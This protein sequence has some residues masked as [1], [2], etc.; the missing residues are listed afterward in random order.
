MTGPLRGVNLGGWLVLE[1]WMTPSLFAGTDAIDEFTFMQSPGAA[2]RLRRHHQ[3]FI[4]QRD[5]AWIADRGLDLV[6]LPVG[7]WVL[8]GDPPYMGAADLLDEAMEWATRHGLAVLL[9]LHAA[10]GSQNGRDHSGRVGARRWY[11]ERGHRE[12]THGALA[13]LAERYARHPA[14]WGIELVNEPTDWR[15]WRLRHFHREAYRRLAAQLAPGTRVVF[16]DGYVPWL[17]RGSLRGTADLP[18]VIDSHFYQAFY[19]WDVVRSVD[20][21]I[22]KARRRARLIEW[23]TRWQPVLVGEWSAGLPARA[24][25]GRGADE[26]LALTTAYV[27]AQLEGYAPALGWCF[28]SYKTEE[29]GDWNFRHLVDSGILRL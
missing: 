7:H 17:L 28:W 11:R 4:T 13:A 8:G 25:R 20:R 14:L 12:H 18:T 1:P 29:A 26:R 19:P 27:D 10:S 2:D 5:F 24:Y 9:D 23:L 22:A 21:H 16:S 6:R 3:T 15:I